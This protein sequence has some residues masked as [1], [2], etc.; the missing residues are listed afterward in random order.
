[1]VI[2]D[3]H[4]HIWERVSGQVGGEKKVLPLGNGKIRIGDDEMLGMPAYMTDCAARAESVI[5]EF[6]AAGVAAGVVVQ[7]YLDGPQNDYLLEVSA[8]YPGRFFVHALADF[9]RVDTVAAEAF[10]LFESGFQGLKLCAGHLQGKLRIDDRRLFPIWER[11]EAEGRVLA[12]DFSEGEQQV[13]EFERVIA[14]YPKLKVAIGHF[15]MPNRDGWPGQL[16]LCRHENVF[17]E[18]GGII[19]LYRSEGYPFPGARKVIREAIN[20]VGVEKLMWG[21]DWPRTMVDYTYRQSL[22]FVEFDDFLNEEEKQAFLGGNAVN[23]YHLSEVQ[24]H[25]RVA[26]ITEG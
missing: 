1:M 5:G 10:E 18:C 22:D 4:M 7:E 6:D 24:E 2:I 19:W 17:M 14:G 12:V 21:S 15:G 20:E 3:S 8:R 16:Q 26:L 25:D 13:E 11:M 23:L 9:F